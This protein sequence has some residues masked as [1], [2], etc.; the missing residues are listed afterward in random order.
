M[1]F[2]LLD[3]RVIAKS[4]VHPFVD[5]NGRIARVL[6]NAELDAALQSRII[7]P[8]VFRE[9]YLLALRRLSRKL[10]PVPY[11]RMLVEAQSFTA[12][13]PYDEYHQTLAKFQASN[14]FLEPNE[15]KL[16]LS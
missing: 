11:V 10:D 16:T 1:E 13:I 5:G 12:S 4:E 9:D 8:T 15:G 14:A 6:M 3:H 2:N 7:I